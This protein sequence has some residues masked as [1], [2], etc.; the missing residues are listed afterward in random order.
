VRLYLDDVYDYGSSRSILGT[1]STYIGYV[2][3]LFV[4][5]VHVLLLLTLASAGACVSDARRGISSTGAK[6]CRGIVAALCGVVWIMAV[7]RFALVCRIQTIGSTLSYL[8]AAG[9]V[10]RIQLAIYVLLLVLGLLVV[11][12]SVSIKMQAKSVQ[13]P[14][15]VGRMPPVHDVI[16]LKLTGARVQPSTYLLVCSVLFLLMAVYQL[17]VF[18]A[19][20]NFGN[21]GQNK[22]WDQFLDALD[23]VFL[24]VP[25]FLIL[26]LLFSLSRMRDGGLWSLPGVGYNVNQPVVVQQV[27]WTQPQMYAQYQQPPQPVNPG[28]NQQHFQQP[29]QTQPQPQ[30]QPHEIHG[31]HV[32]TWHEMPQPAYRESMGPKTGA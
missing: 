31:A 14:D 21:A 8:R 19:Y 32:P 1:A 17:G 27:A 7:A 24:Y 30:P 22:S 4:S 5:W 10:N 25:G 3:T 11:G 16:V 29:R 28:W 15:K 26:V 23:V 20:V 13:K 18:A 12:W 2:S 6:V 9:D